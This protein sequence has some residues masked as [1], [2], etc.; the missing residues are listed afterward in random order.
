M[1]IQHV[2]VP[3]YWTPRGFTIV[4]IK[5]TDKSYFWNVKIKFEELFSDF[6]P[7]YDI[8]FFLDPRGYERSI[9]WF[10]KK[11]A[12]AQLQIWELKIDYDEKIRK[13]YR[14]YEYEANQLKVWSFLQIRLSEYKA[15][16]IKDCDTLTLL[17]H[18]NF[19]QFLLENSIWIH[20]MCI[21]MNQ[22]KGYKAQDLLIQS[23][24]MTHNDVNDTFK[25]WP[26]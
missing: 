4:E 23:W 10:Y 16:N 8:H 18:D 21:V 25:L 14:E 17:M 24:D 22:H 19:I 7:L 12:E 6:F 1:A 26:E 11:K 15:D 13:A 9:E 3:Q 2:T 20:R 5:K